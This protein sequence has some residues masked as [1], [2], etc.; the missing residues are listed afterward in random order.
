MSTIRFIDSSEL[1]IV[2]DLF[3]IDNRLI[4]EPVDG[5][6]FERMLTNWKHQLDTGLFKVN[7]LFSDDGEPLAM[8]SGKMFPK[9]R[10]WWVG[11]TKV[12]HTA[13]H[14]NQS[15]RIMSPALTYMLNYMESQGYY[16]FWMGAPVQHHNIRNQVMKKFCPRLCDYEWFDE[17]IIP[18]N[19]RC[20]IDIWEQNRRTCS[21]SDIT[22]RMFV[23]KQD[24]RVPL[25][26]AERERLN[27]QIL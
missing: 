14:F 17:Y 9:V 15:A 27:V 20:E 7:V 5:E 3:S 19:E 12:K 23:L 22:I 1:D 26:Q 4:G 2:R 11:A 21:W 16:K 18:Q 6:F 8:Y 25:V 13:N 10:G 24:C